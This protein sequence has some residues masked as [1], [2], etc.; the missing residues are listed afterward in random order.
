MPSEN[1]FI[2]FDLD[3]FLKENR[4]CLVAPAGYGKTHAIISSLR[5]LQN[6]QLI[7]THTHAGVASIKK[8]LAKA[9]IPSSRYELSTIS[10]F[11][12]RLA[13]AYTHNS[14]VE[15]KS[16]RNRAYFNWAISRAKELMGC[17]F[18]RDIITSSYAGV[19]VDEYQDCTV[20]QHNLI[21]EIAKRLPLRVLGDPWQ[22]I[23]DLHED[24]PIVDFDTHLSGFANYSLS[25]P[26][27]WLK[28]NPGLGN[29]IADLR[30]QI[31]TGPCLDFSQFV[32]IKY[33]KLSFL[34]YQKRLPELCRSLYKNGGTTVIIVSDSKRRDAK[35][36]VARLFNGR[37]SVVEAIDDKEFYELAQLIDDL[38][39]ENAK[40]V[41]YEVTSRLFFKSCVD[42]WINNAGVIKKRDEKKRQESRALHDALEQLSLSPTPGHFCSCL[43]YFIGLPN[44]VTLRHEKYYALVSALQISIDN[45]ASVLDS[46]IQARDM[47]RAMGRMLKRFAV[48]TTLL[49][50]GLEF[51]NVIVV[52]K[53][54]KFQM[55]TL[56]GRRNFYVAISRACR[57]LFILDVD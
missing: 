36:G 10:S 51:D 30:R 13:V 44:I 16:M 49:T 25:K 48:G 57:K 40:A 3:Q 5:K 27:R 23:F 19:I 6:R 12:Q 18:I 38:T 31:A 8:Q 28:T 1:G 9:G 53:K 54:E 22:G 34:E 15:R 50:K 26:Y 2:M 37:C 46:M 11:A 45:G 14:L 55:H 24:D 52:N 4:A 39:M 20:R 32:E 35:L 7:L 41:F 42:E 47:I 21:L 33:R 29:E 17:S 43:Y 56:S